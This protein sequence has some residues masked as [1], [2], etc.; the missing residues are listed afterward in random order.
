MKF[1]VPLIIK[2][3]PEASIGFGFW[4]CQTFQSV[5]LK[6]FVE[7]GGVELKETAHRGML[8][9]RDCMEKLACREAPYP[10]ALNYLGLLYEQEGLRN[11]AERM[12]TRYNIQQIT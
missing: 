2:Y 10:C 9:A 6:L 3:Q 12:F 11:A 1:I 4:V 5:P 7:Q 8:Q